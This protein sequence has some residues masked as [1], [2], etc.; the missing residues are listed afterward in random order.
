MGV[1]GV[2]PDLVVGGL[3]SYTQLSGTGMGMGTGMGRGTAT[4]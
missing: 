3:K 4:A 2:A 1:A